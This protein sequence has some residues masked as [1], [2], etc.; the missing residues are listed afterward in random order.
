MFLM[1]GGLNDNN[2]LC[3]LLTSVKNW[4]DDTVLI[5]KGK[6]QDKNLQ[7]TYS[8]LDIPGKIIW[9]FTSFSPKKLHSLIK[10]CSASF[11]LYRNIHDNFRYIGK[12]SGKIM[13]SLACGRPVIG[14]KNSSL[15]FIEKLELG[16]LIEHPLDIAHAVNYII[17]NEKRVEQFLLFI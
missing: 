9:D 15:D 8:H 7:R 13:R 17:E 12:S 14:S 5:L 3:E 6:N 16:A 10:Y 2:Q 11:G 4:R 1:A